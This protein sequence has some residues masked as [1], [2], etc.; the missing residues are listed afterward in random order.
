MYVSMLTS[1]VTLSETLKVL[2]TFYGKVCRV[3]LQFSLMPSKSEIIFWLSFGHDH[4]TSTLRCLN[5]YSHEMTAFQTPHC[6]L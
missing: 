3:A 6:R 4:I 2:G 5:Y 1:Q